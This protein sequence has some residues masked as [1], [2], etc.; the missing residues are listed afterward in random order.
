MT[1]VVAG[2]D[3]S[4]ESG[5]AAGEQ[6]LAGSKPPT[7]IFCFNDEMAIGVL[8]AARQH[9]LQVPNDLSVIGF[10]DIRFAQ[11]VDPPLTTIRQPM[12]ELGEATVRLLLNILARQRQ[13]G[14]V[15]DPAARR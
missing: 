14:G 8:H 1:I 10:D 6:L 12:R 5:I 4:I 15:G 13:R 2:G 11:Y 9:G 3:F 7:A